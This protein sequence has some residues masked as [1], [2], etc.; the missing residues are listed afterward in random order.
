MLLQASLL[1]LRA[2]P[3][4]MASGTV[5][6]ARNI[7]GQGAVASALVQRVTPT[8]TR[9]LTLT[10]TLTR[11]A[12]SIEEAKAKAEAAIALGKMKLY[13]NPNPN[14]NPHPNPNP[15][16]NQVFALDLE[17]LM[18][19]LNASHVHFVRCIKPNDALTPGA[20]NPNPNPNPHPHPNLNQDTLE[21]RARV[22][23]A[24]FPK[25][26]AEGGEEVVECELFPG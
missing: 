9:T 26:K 10:L 5:L 8:R 25:L 18:G 22:L 12:A 19:E 14:P 3:D 11:R 6:E 17:G 4:R 16:P 24:W 13:P 1:N 21:R 7:V 15:N 20:Y 2:N 23:T